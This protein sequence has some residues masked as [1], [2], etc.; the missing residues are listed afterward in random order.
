MLQRSTTFIRKRELRYTISMSTASIYL[1]CSIE[2]HITKIHRQVS[3]LWCWSCPLPMW[4]LE[5]RWRMSP[6][7]MM[8][9][10]GFLRS[11]WRVWMLIRNRRRLSW[12]MSIVKCTI[13]RMLLHWDRDRD[14]TIFISSTSLLNP[15]NWIYSNGYSLKYIAC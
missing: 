7:R 11:L 2:D 10:K 15:H 3:S 6:L 13:L 14:I 4:W 1:S 9:F 12:W 8:N 5:F